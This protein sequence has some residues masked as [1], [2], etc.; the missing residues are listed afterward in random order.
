MID[1][2]RR[3]VSSTAATPTQTPISLRFRNGTTTRAP[4][5]TAFVNGPSARYEN[6][7]NSGSGSATST[8][9]S[10]AARLARVASPNAESGGIGDGHHAAGNRRARE[11]IPREQ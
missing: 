7:V 3:F 4:G 10:V 1:L 2:Y 6:V 5:A 11:R 9:T 8:S